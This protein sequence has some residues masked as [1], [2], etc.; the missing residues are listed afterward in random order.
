M[1]TQPDPN[2]KRRALQASGTFNPGH[3][4]VRHAL[5]QQSDFFDPCDLPQ[6]KYEMLRALQQ[7]GYSIVR[8]AVEFGLSRPTIYQTQNHFQEHGLEGL[9]PEKPG[10]KSPHKLTA[11]VRQHLGEL[12]QAEPELRA[13]ELARRVRR[14]FGVKLHPRTIEKALQSK[15]KRGRQNPP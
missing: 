8:A 10:P 9:L 12:I 2:P 15:A 13:P 14:R 7:E 1:P 11:E 3:A 4:R 6:L 5:F